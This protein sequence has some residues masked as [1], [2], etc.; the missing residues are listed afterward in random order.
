MAAE[1]GRVGQ[2]IGADLSSVRPAGTDTHRGRPVDVRDAI[3]LPA[4]GLFHVG[5]GDQQ[6]YAEEGISYVIEVTNIPN[7]T[8]P[9]LYEESAVLQ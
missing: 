3:G 2:R 9:V 5:A 7:G 8:D 1:A 4:S 6:E